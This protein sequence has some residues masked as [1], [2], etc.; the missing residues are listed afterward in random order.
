MPVQAKVTARRGALTVKVTDLAGRP[1]AHLTGGLAI[2]PGA[3][4]RWETTFG[5]TD[6]N[7]KFTLAAPLG[8]YK[9][10]FVLIQQSK[11]TFEYRSEPVDVR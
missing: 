4:D 6:R 1:M 8:P 11:D 5:R 9:V 2:P 7:G 10:N 3:E